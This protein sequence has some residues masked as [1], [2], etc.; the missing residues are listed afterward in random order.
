MKTNKILRKATVMVSLSGAI[1]VQAQEAIPASGGNAGGRGGTASYTVGQTVY[2]SISGSTGSVSQGVQQAFQITV[3]S[4]VEGAGEITLEMEVFPNPTTEYLTL[5]I[6]DA[7]TRDLSYQLSDMNG[8]QLEKKRVEGN[9]TGI[10]MSNYAQATYFLKIL[11][12]NK[13]VKTFQIIKN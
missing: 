10:A 11:D 1:A 2:T 6:D 12:G 3:A 13:E 4:A 9:Q 8:K 7:E 5:N